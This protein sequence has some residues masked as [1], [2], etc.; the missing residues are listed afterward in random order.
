LIIG[1]NV[2]IGRG[3][4]DILAEHRGTRV[5]VEVKSA[6]LDHEGRADPLGAFDDANARQV[7]SLA[8]QVGAWRVDVVAVGFRPDGVQVRW[9]PDV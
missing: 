9:V 4:I 2:R 8:R 1:R 3:E 5:A 6:V 7:W